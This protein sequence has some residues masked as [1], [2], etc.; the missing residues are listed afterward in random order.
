LVGFMSMPSDKIMDMF[1]KFPTEEMK[2]E[3]GLD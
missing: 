1:A 2:K 3:A